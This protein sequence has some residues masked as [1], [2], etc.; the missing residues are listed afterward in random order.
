[1]NLG[2]CLILILLFYKS[3]VITE[4]CN[5]GMTPDYPPD[6]DSESDELDMRQMATF[7]VTDWIKLTMEPAVSR[8]LNHCQIILLFYLLDYLF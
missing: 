3:D 1:M 4:P 2:C 7:S 6:S 5:T 8:I